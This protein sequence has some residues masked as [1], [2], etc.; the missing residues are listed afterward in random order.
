M[1]KI[2]QCRSVKLLAFKIRD[3]G[4]SLFLCLFTLYRTLKKNTIQKLYATKMTHYVDM[5]IHPRYN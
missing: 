5:E 3:G 1:V 4:T 2:Y